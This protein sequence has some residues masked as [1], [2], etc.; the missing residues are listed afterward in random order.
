[1]IAIVNIIGALA[2]PIYLSLFPS[3]NSD[4]I[5]LVLY[6]LLSNHCLIPVILG[7]NYF[8]L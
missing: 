6:D 1:M 5:S 7:F 2:F 4:Q 8:L 3:F